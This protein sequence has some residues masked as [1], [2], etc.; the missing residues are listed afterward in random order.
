MSASDIA[1]LLPVAIGFALSPAA[2]IELI[3]VLFSHRRVTN[4][5]VFVIALVITTSAALALGALGSSASGDSGGDTSTVASWAFVAFGLL[6]VAMGVANWRKRTDTSEPP[7]F[8]AIASMGPA[9]V[10]FLSLGVTFINPKNLPLLLS[11]GATIGSTDAPWLAGAAFVVVG[12]LP[13]TGAMLYSLL[14]GDRSTATLERLR[15]WLVAN[16]RLIMA[17][18]CSLLGILLLVKGITALT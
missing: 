18:L 12:T 7:V 15:D 8:Q 10:A 2:I 16:N 9:A 6:L 13:Y 4:S 17:V 1:T 11:A 14:G 5:I 3:L